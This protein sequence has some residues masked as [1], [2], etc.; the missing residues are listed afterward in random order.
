MYFKLSL[1]IS[2]WIFPQEYPL[3]FDSNQRE[4][5]LKGKSISFMQV[6]NRDPEWKNVVVSKVVGKKEV[7][8]VFDSCSNKSN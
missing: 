8:Q 7:S 2:L 4:T 3:S 6:G 1:Q 5:L